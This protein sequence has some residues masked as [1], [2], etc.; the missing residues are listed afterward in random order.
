MKGNDKVSR[1]EDGCDKADKNMLRLEKTVV[2]DKVD[3]KT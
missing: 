2:V 1:K 3:D